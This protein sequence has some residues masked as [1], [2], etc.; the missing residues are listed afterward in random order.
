MKYS[1]YGE[2]VFFIDFTVWILLY[3][4]LTIGMLRVPMFKNLEIF[5]LCL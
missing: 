4:N 5:V 2:G 1:I 3:F